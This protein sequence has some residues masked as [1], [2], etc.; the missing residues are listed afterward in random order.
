MNR[1]APASVMRYVRYVIQIYGLPRL[2]IS[3]LTGLDYSL[4]V[5][6]FAGEIIGKGYLH[7]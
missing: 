7:C 5:E 3:F 4:F 6:Y 2:E 1:T